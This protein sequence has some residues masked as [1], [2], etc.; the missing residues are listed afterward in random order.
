MSINGIWSD[1][2]WCSE[3][4]GFLRETVHGICS[5][6]ASCSRR[7]FLKTVELPCGAG[8]G[9]ATGCSNWLFALASQSVCVGGD[10]FDLFAKIHAV[11]IALVKT[12]AMALLLKVLIFANI[13]YESLK[14]LVCKKSKPSTVAADSFVYLHDSRH[15][16]TISLRSYLPGLLGQVCW[17]PAGPALTELFIHQSV[18][19]SQLSIHLFCFDDVW[20]VSLPNRYHRWIIEK[21][22]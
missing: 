20:Y 21:V 6:C 13:S 17:H 11:I 2:K 3:F 14:D 8:F 22:M 15:Q 9:P 7:R 10:E 1:H 19:G 16:T 12:M 18:W 5:L 4:G